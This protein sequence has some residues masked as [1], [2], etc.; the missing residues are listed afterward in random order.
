MNIRTRPSLTTAAAKAA[1]VLESGGTIS[2]AARAAGVS[3][4]TVYAWIKRGPAFQH[5]T[6]ESRIASELVRKTETNILARLAFGA[7]A[8]ILS[9]DELPASVR[10][11]VAFAVLE[12]GNIE[13]SS[14]GVPDP[15]L[16]HDASFPKPA[17]A[18]L[19][20]EARRLYTFTTALDTNVIPQTLTTKHLGPNIDVKPEKEVVYTAA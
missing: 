20:A 3:R 6:L 14:W 13:G 10:A 8:Q 15:I 16:E 12:R 11:R 4:P 18:A 2:E 7:I 19:T 9:N 1:K 17:V 5:H